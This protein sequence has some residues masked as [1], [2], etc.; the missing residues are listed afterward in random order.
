MGE[1]LGN[2]SIRV[3]LI[4]SIKVDSTLKITRGDWFVSSDFPGVS[5][6]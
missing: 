6:S 3:N 2:G 1:D 5:K 4:G